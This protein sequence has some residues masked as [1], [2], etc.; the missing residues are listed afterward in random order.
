[1]IRRTCF[2]PRSSGPGVCGLCGSR[3]ARTARRSWSRD[4][5]VGGVEPFVEPA[6]AEAEGAVSGE[7]LDPGA[8]AL[9]APPVEAAPGD[10]QLGADLFDGQPLVSH[11]VRVTGCPGF[12]VHLPRAVVSC[13][14]LAGPAGVA[15]F[16]AVAAR[17]LHGGADGS[18]SGAGCWP[19][20]VIRSLL[21][22]RA[23]APGRARAGFVILR[24]AFG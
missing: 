8:G 22:A 10:L 1:M 21:R 7:V 5:L 18:R 3:S 15:R 23:R 2:R 16:G 20:P 9:G 14:C 24:A 12:H 6:A 17:E 19:P 11:G 4:V 13:A